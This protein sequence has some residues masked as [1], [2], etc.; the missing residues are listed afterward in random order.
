MRNR[1]LDNLKKRAFNELRKIKKESLYAEWK[2]LVLDVNA[3]KLDA[4]AVSR[5][6][7]GLM[8]GDCHSKRASD[9]IEKCSIKPFF[10]MYNQINSEINSLGRVYSVMRNFT[11]LETVLYYDKEWVKNKIN[12]LNEEQVN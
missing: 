10:E 4:S 6:V 7:Y 5:C 9:L 11:A 2:I 1:K 3:E 8:T 12:K